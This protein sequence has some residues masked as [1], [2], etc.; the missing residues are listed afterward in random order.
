MAT[1]PKNTPKA[2]PAGRGLKVIS[3]REGFRRAGHVFGREPVTVSLAALTPEQ[4]QALLDEPALACVEV[5]L[6]AD[7]A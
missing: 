4:H 3:A 5:D 6:A 2:G 7:A 1:T